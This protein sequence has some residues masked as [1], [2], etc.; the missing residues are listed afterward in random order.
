MS[1]DDLQATQGRDMA[2]EGVA[3]QENPFPASKGW[4]KMSDPGY[5]EW[6]RRCRYIINNYYIPHYLPSKEAFASGIM[7][8][9]DINKYHLKY[10]AEVDR[11]LLYTILVFLKD[12]DT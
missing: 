6:S 8:I 4:K 2:T 11:L 1:A 9:D 7:G 3:G 12:E 10:E 5:R